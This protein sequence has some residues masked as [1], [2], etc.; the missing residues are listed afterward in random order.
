[1]LGLVLKDGSYAL[2][3]S[4][5]VGL[6]GL[7]GLNISGTF[8][9]RSNQL[10]VPVN[11]S[12]W[13]PAGNVP[14]VFSSGDKILSFGGS[15]VISVAGIFEISGTV[16][17]TKTSSGLILVDIPQISAALNING[18]R[19]FEVGGK[20]RFSIGGA[21]GFQLLDIGLTTVVVMGVNV[22]AIAGALPSLTLP[23]EVSVPAAAEL[24]TIVDGIDA[25]VLNR[26]KYID[27]TLQTPGSGTLNIESVLDSGAEFTLSGQGVADAQI[28]SVQHLEGN[29][30]RYFLTDRD[31]SNETLLFRPG[32][33]N[34]SFS[35]GSWADSTGATNVAA[36]D[37]FTARDGKATTASSVNLGPLSLTG[38]YFGLEDFQF[39]PLKNADGSLKGARI[40][41]TV[42]LGVENASFSFGGSSSALSTSITDLDGLFDVNVD[43][44]P[45]LDI[46]G[47]GMGKF[48][49]DVGSMTLNVF[50]VLIAEASGVTIQYNPEKDTDGDGVV[51]AEEQS[52]YDN[53]EIL[54][55]QNATVTITK[56]DLTGSLRPY[57]TRS[58]R[59]IPGLVVRNNGFHLGEAE[60]M[61]SGD[62]E[63]GSILNLEDIR[64]GIA[65]FGVNFS[66]GVQFNGEVYIA[67][68]GAELFPGKTFSM[69]FKDGSDAN[70]EA[71]R[72]GLTFKD[73]IPAGFKFDSDEMSMKFGDFLTVSSTKLVINTEAKGSEYVVSVGSISA[74]VKAGPLKVK[75]TLKNF[76]ITGSGT[77]VTLPGF[78]VALSMKE[79][80]PDSF[81]WPSWL[82]IT[83]TSLGIEWPDI[84]ANP[85]NF[86]LIISAK[87]NK[88]PGVPLDF[89]GAVTGLKI[90]L[91]LL[92]QGK[93]PITEV[94]S[95]A[96]T[97]G[98]D[99]GGAEISGSLLGG[100]LKLDST[101]KVIEPTDTTSVVTDRVFFVAVEGKLTILNKGFQVRFALSELGPLS[102]FVSVKAPIVLE[103]VFTGI[104]IN[105][106][107]G[108]IE[109]FTGLPTIT[110]PEELLGK[111]F[112]DAT[113][114]DADTWLST[115]KQQVA[116]QVKQVKA[117]PNIPG[118][119]AAFISPMTITAQA[120]I[121]STHLG[122]EDS[123][124]GQVQMR[125]STDGKLFAAGKFRFMN[126]RLVVEGKMYA[127]LS[128]ITKGNAKVLFLGRAPV[129]E[130]APDLR[131]LE[132]KGK[133]E[134][135]FIGPNGQPMTFSPVAAAEPSANLASPGSGA[136]IGIQKLT[137]QGYI[138]VNFVDGKKTLSES[139]ITD[140]SSELRLLLPNGTT[141]EITSTPT[142][143]TTA[144]D[145]NVYRYNLPSGISLVPG[146]YTVQFIADGVTDSDGKG[147]KYEE[148]T[149]EVAVP[150]SELAGPKHNAQIDVLGLNNSGYLTVR[151][152]GL[153]GLTL[154]ESSIT[155]A[156]AEF[157]LSGAAAA[158]V[159]INQAPEKVDATTWKYKFTGQFT[160]GP[161]S[162]SFPAGAFTDS[163][164]NS[165]VA[166]M[167][168]FTV[169]GPKITL[170]SKSMD[171]SALNAQ[172]YMEFYVE[173]SSGGTI[174]DATLTDAAHEFS[175]SGMSTANVVF[176]GAAVRQGDTQVYRYN[177]T[178]AFT[179]GEAVFSFT[180]G[181]FT[182]STNLGNVG[183]TET[184]L[185]RGAAATRVSPA[186]TVVGVSALNSQ[187]YLDVRFTPTTGY[188][189][190]TASI[191]DSGDEIL[192]TGNAADDV[193]LS[194][195][196]TQVDDVT[197]RYSFTGEFKPGSMTLMFLEG[198]MQD[199]NGAGLTPDSE[200]LEL[201][202]LTS[203]LINPGHQS[204]AG[205]NKL[206]ANGYID[207]QLD[208]VLG[209]GL[210]ESSLTDTDAEIELFTYDKDGKEQK[211]TGIGVNGVAEH[212]E[213]STWRYRFSGR[214]EPGQV[215]VRFHK[216]SWSDNAG[217]L[218]LEKIET[219]N[220]Y[221][222]AASFEIIV[223]GSAELYGA[224]ED[225]KL[226]SIKG[227]AKLS[228]DIS[229]D[230]PSARIQLDLNGR[231]DVMYFGTVGA[232]SGRFIFEI[233]PG[234]NSGFWGVMKMDT[235]F[236]KLRP[237]GIDMDATGYLQFNFSNETKI[238]TLTLPGQGPGG[239]DLTETYTLA[240]WLFAFQA[241][242][243]LIFHVPDFNEDTVF[244]T[245]LFRMSG[246]FSLEISQ[247]G[248][249]VLA[250]GTLTI[251]PSELNL[252]TLDII[253][254]L[255]IKEN[256]FAAD[257]IVTA[258]A[259]V[260]DLAS[261][262]GN[263]RL[264]TNTSGVDQEIKVPQRFIDGGYLPQSFLGRLQ[265]TADPTDDAEQQAY[266]VNAGPPLWEGGFGTPGFYA[267]MQGRASMYLRDAFV[268]EAAFRFEVSVNGLFMQAEGGLILKDIGQ[269][270][271][272]GYLEFTSAGLVVAMSLDL[273]APAL[274]TI[275]IDLDVN[276]ELLLNTTDSSKTIKPLTDGLLLED[277][278]VPANTADIKAEG[279]LAVRIPGTD[280]ELA[281]ISGVFSLD[282]ST[283]RVS[284][285]SH[286]DLEIG[287][288]GLRVFDMEV[289][290]VF[291]VVEEGFAADLTITATG[292][293]PSVAELTG[294]LRL[295][296]N[297]T[298]LAQEVPVPQRF[299]DGGFLPADFVNRLSDSALFPGRKSY[300][301]PA[302]AP[303]LDGTP[304]DPA[305]TYIVLMGQATLTLVDAWDITGG[306]RI[307][308]ETD[309]PVI[310]I[311]AKLDLG[312]LGQAN[313]D[314]KVELRVS[315]LTAVVN[316]DMDFPGL[317]AA[318]V[319]FTA[320][321]LLKV[322]TGSQDA[323]VDVDD[324]PATPSILLEAKSSSLMV[325]GSLVVRVPQTQVELISITGTFMLLI[326]SDGLSVL[327]SGQTSL[328]SLVT[329]QVDGAFF[330]RSS[331]VAAEIDMALIPGAAAAA[332]S[333][334]FNFS[335]T[336]T[337]A[338]NTT[339]APQAIEV[340]Q[341][342][343]GYLSDRAKSRL[344]T[345]GPRKYYVVPAGPKNVD[346][347]YEPAGPYAVFLM[348]GNV[349]IS[350]V[351]EIQ[352][353]F[354][355]VAANSRFEV[356]FDAY[357]TLDP[358]GRVDASGI[359]N[360]SS[361]GVYG[362]LQLGGKF[363]LGSLEIFG[364]MQLE[365]NTLST[366]VSIE[367]VQYDFE[368]RRVSDGKV[369][370]VLPA[371]AQ[372]VFVGGILSFPGFE[373]KGSFELLN[374]SDVISVS[375]D[376]SFR[377]FDALTLQ[378][379]GTVSIVKGSNPGLVM[380]VD[381]TLKA[382]FFGVEGVFDMNANFRMKVNTRTGN[383][384]DAYDLG[385]LRGMSRIDVSGEIKLL[386]TL[387]LQASGFI[388]SYAGVFRLE[389]NASM[390]ILSQNVWGTGYFSSEGEFKLAFGGSLNIGASGFGVFGSCS[391]EISRL[392][393]NG[394][395]AFGDGNYV[396]K[397]YGNMQG[398]VQMF[399]F[400]LASASITLN[401]ED[402][403]GRVYITARIQLDLLVTKV[404][405]SSSFTL[406]YI[407]I[408]KP[409]YLA[410]N[411]GDTAGTGFNRGILYLNM[412]ARAH[413]RNEAEDDANEGYLLER[414]APDPE[415]PGE[416]IRVQAFGRSQTFRG[417]TGIV[418][419]GG[420][421][422]DYI[423]IGPGIMSP[424]TLKG[425]DRKDW[426]RH[427]G[428]GTGII[429]G[430]A[431]DD[432]ILGGYGLNTF[433]FGNGFGR[434]SVHS[435]SEQN[436]FDFSSATENLSGQLTQSRLEVV[437][438]G[439]NR[440]A[441]SVE[442]GGRAGLL[443]SMGD[444]RRAVV[445][446]NHG[447]AVG[448]KVQVSCPGNVDFDGE[449]TVTS[450]TANSFEF[451]TFNLRQPA[452]TG[453]STNAGPVWHDGNQ[454]AYIRTVIDNWA[455]GH[456]LALE[457]STNAYNGVFEVQKISDSL[458]SFRTNWSDVR[459]VLD[460]TVRPGTVTL[461]TGSDTFSIPGSLAG[462]LNLFAPA[463]GTD[464]L[465]IVGS[466]LQ[467]Q[468]IVPG[469]YVNSGLTVLYSGIDRLELVDTSVDLTLSG[470]TSSD[471]VLLGSIGLGVAARSLNLPVSV[472]ADSIEINVRDSFTQLQTLQSNDLNIR[473]FGDDQNIS[474]S[475]PV[476]ASRSVQLIAPD[477]TIEL[478]GGG[479]ITS[480]SIVLKSLGLAVA[481]DLLSLSTDRL[482]VITS[483]TTAQNLTIHNDRSLL[484]TSA[485]DSTHMVQLDLTLTDVFAGISW[486]ATV[487][488]DWAAQ[489]FDGAFNPWAVAVAGIL[490]VQLPVSTASNEY[491]L[492][493]IGGL[494]SW[495][496]DIRLTADEMDFLGGPGTI[497]ATGGLTLQAASDA[498][499]Y[500]LGTSAESGG[501]A[502]VDPQYAPGMLDLPTRDIAALADGFS[503]ITI[504]R[505]SA[506]NV[507]RLGDAYSMTSVKATGEARAVDASIK[508]PI[509]LLTDSLI[510]E[511][512]FRAPL[513]S[514][515]I[516]AGRT[517]VRKV[518]LHTPNN[519]QPDSGLS[520]TTVALDVSGGLQV[521]GWIRGNNT[522]SIQ[523]TDT[524]GNY[525]L[526]TDQG[527]EILQ[528]GAAGALAITVDRGLRIAG[529]VQAAAANAS[530]AI[531][532]GTSFELLAGGDLS[533]SA[534]NSEL[535]LTGGTDIAFYP[536][537]TVR[538]GVAI[539]YPAGSP[540]YTVTGTGGQI[541]ILS[542]KE[543]LLGGLIVSSGG[544]SITAGRNSRNHASEFAALYSSNPAHYMAEHDSY[545]VLLT[546]TLT[547]LGNNEELVLSGQDEVVVTGN[548]QV[549]G[550]GS[551]L[552][553]HSEKF[554]FVEGRL[555]VSDRLAIRGGT[556]LDGTS[557]DA[558]DTR[559]SSVYL[560]AA[561]LISTTQAGS[562]ITVTGARDV[563]IYAAL[564]SGGTV[565]AGG[566]T[567][568]GD[569]S[570]VSVTAGQQIYL[571]APLHAAGS[572]LL[573]PGVPGTDDAAQ[574]L[575]MTTA[576]GLNAAGLGA[577][578]TGSVIRIESD[579]DLTLGG[580]ILSGGTI[581]Q[582]FGA[583]SQLLS[584]TYTWSGRDS[585][586]EIVSSG[587]VLVGTDAVDINGNPV[588][589]G[590]FLRASQSVS[591][592][593]DTDANGVG[594]EVYAG[595]GIT[596]NNASGA[597]LLDSAGDIDLFGM[598]VSGGQISLVQDSSG[599]TTGY[600]VTRHNGAA[601]LEI[602]SDGRVR[603]GQEVYAGKSLKITA[604][605][606]SPVAGDAYSGI[607]IV[608]QG[609]STLRT[610]TANSE[611]ILSSQS[612]IS[613][614]TS[615]TPSPETY[616]IY[617]PGSGSSVV[618]EIAT[619]SA[620]GSAIQI[621]GRIFADREIA[622]TFRPDAA[623]A[624]DLEV[625]GA[626]NIEVASST[627]R[628]DLAAGGNLL[629]RG[630][631]NSGGE[632]TL[633]ADSGTLTLTPVSRLNAATQI[634]LAAGVDVLIDSP[635]GITTAP[636]RFSAAAP[637]GSVI[638]TAA[639][640]RIYAANTVELTGE[641][642]DFNGVLQTTAATVATEDYEISIAAD[643]IKLT[644]SLSAVGSLRIDS[645]TAP[646]IY[647]FTAD[648]TAP[649]SRVQ[650]TA[651][652][653]VDI[654]R[655]TLNDAGKWIAQTA[656]I[657]ATHGISISAPGQQVTVH[658]GSV[659]STSGD[660]SSTAI[661]GGKI[662][663]VGS[664]YGG[665]RVNSDSTPTWTGTDA[666]L[667]FTASEIA[668]G[669][670]GV[671]PCGKQ[672]TRGGSVQ[673]TGDIVF[674]AIG[675]GLASEFSVNS[676]SY[677]RTMP[678]GSEA[679]PNHSE[680]ASISAFSD[681]GLAI[682]GIVD[683]SGTGADL[684]LDADDA[685]LLDGIVTA[686]DRLNVSSRGAATGIELT[687]LLF[688]TN[689]AGQLLNQNGDAIDVN[690]YLIDSAGRFIDA[691]GNL[692]PPGATP[693]SGGQPSRLSGGTLNAD[694][695]SLTASADIRLLGQTG[696]LTV[697]ANSLTSETGDLSVNAG[698]TLTV[699]GRQQ[700]SRLVDL[701]AG[702]LVVQPDAVVLAT[703]TVH[704]LGGTS[705]IEGYAGSPDKVVL[706]A[707]SSLM[708]TG[709]VQSGNRINAAAGVSAS[710]NLGQLVSDSILSSQL[711]GGSISVEQ[712]GV[713]DAGNEIRVVSGGSFDLSADAVVTPNLASITEPVIV[714]REQQISVVTGTRQVA[715]GSQLVDVITYVPTEVTEQ[716]GSTTLRVGTAYHT[717]DVALTQEGY[718]N[719][720]THREFFVQNVDYENETI[721]WTSYERLPLG[722]VRK[723][724]Q[725]PA[726]QDAVSAPE[727]TATFAQLTDD[728]KSVVLAEL[729]YLRLYR[730]SYTN[731]RRHQT[732][733]GNT[734]ITAWTPR[735]ANDPVFIHR[736]SFPGLSDKHI[737][738]PEGA[739]QDFF[740]VVSQ[741]YQ[742]IPVET[743]GQYR[744][745]ADLN[746]VQDRS[747][748][749][750]STDFQDYDQQSGR[751]YVTAVPTSP[752]VIDGEEQTVR[753]G[754][755]QYE[756]FDGRVI[757]GSGSVDRSLQHVF[758]P[759]WF[760]SPAT[761]GN[762]QSS[763][764]IGVDSYGER[765]I[766]PDG[767]LPD[768]AYVAN[769]TE[770]N[771]RP[772]IWV[773]SQRLRNFTV[774]RMESLVNSTGGWTYPPA[775]YGW[776]PGYSRLTRNDP[777]F[778]PA[779]QVESRG[780]SLSEYLGYE[781]SGIVAEYHRG[782]G[783]PACLFG[784]AYWDIWGAAEY[785]YNVFRKHYE[786]YRDYQVAWTGNWH[787]ITDYRDQYQ[788]EWRTLTEDVFG[789]VPT[790]ATFT[791][792][793]PIVQQEAQT[794]WVSENVV[795]QRT[796]IV[797]ERVENS[798]SGLPTAA[799]T[800]ESL[801][802][803]DRVSIDV[804]QDASFIGLTRATSA[805]G[806]VRVRA[807]RDVILDGKSLTDA[808]PGTLA[809]V[810]DLRAGLT[811][812]VFAQRNVELRSDAIVHAD[813]GDTATNDGVIRLHAGQ[814]LTVRSDAFGG[815]EI[816]LHS[817]G[818]VLM[819]S[820]MT[821]GHL[822][823]VRAGLGPAGVGSVITSLQT[824]LETLGS[825]IVLAAGS[826]GG[827]L[828]LTNA[829]ILTAGPIT[830]SAPAG[831][832]VHSG[833]MIVADTLSAT[834]RDNIE[835]A[836]NVRTVNAASTGAGN[837][838]LQTQG[839]VTLADISTAAG[840]VSV[841]GFGPIT[842]GSIVAG[843]S[844]GDVSIE[845]L[846]GDV[847]LGDIT[848]GG[849]LTVESDFGQISRTPGTSIAADEVLWVGELDASFELDSGDVTLIT[850]TPGDVVINYSGSSPL[851]LRQVY[852]LEGSLIVNTPGDLIVMDARLLS[853]NENYLITLNAGGNVSLGYLEAGEY[854]ATD[855][856]ADAIRQARGLEADAPLTS[857]STVTI[858]AGGWIGE[859]GAGDS[860][861][862]LVAGRAVL[863]A[864]T[865]IN[866]VTIAVNEL[867]SAIST[868]GAITIVDQD[869]VGE[870]TPG[871][872]A[873]TLSAPGGVSLIASG[874]LS[875]E[876]VI[877]SGGSAGITLKSGNSLTLTPAAGATQML[878][879]G[880][881]IAL[882]GSSILWQ[883]INQAGAAV[884]AVATSG[885]LLIADNTFRLTSGSLSVTAAGDLSVDGL[886][887]A[888]GD[889]SL[890]SISG[891]QSM[892]ADIQAGTGAAIQTLKF[893]AARDLNLLQ[894]SFPN[895][896][897]RLTISAGHELAQ[898]QS[899]LNW[900]ATGT[901]GELIV[902]AGGNLV[903][904]EAELLQSILKADYRISISSNSYI[905]DNGEERGGNLAVVSVPTGWS[906]ASTRFLTLYA[907]HY[908]HLHESFTAN[909]NLKMRGGQTMITRRAIL[910]NLAG[911]ILAD[912]PG[913]E[914]ILTQLSK[915]VAT[916]SGTKLELTEGTILKLEQQEGSG[917][918]FASD[919]EIVL[920]AGE[921]IVQVDTVAAKD[922]EADSNRNVVA[923][924]TTMA[925]ALT[926][927]GS[928]V[929]R[930]D[931]VL[932]LGA[933]NT[934]TGRTVVEAG[935]L[936]INGSTAPQSNVE[937]LG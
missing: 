747:S 666:D 306:F 303:Y 769:K 671:C 594:I 719:G 373:M 96:V 450:V 705:R 577:N 767:F 768:T 881:S 479:Q 250:Q 686:T 67:S 565:G 25:G 596:T 79:A 708:V 466:L 892:A 915:S 363:Q 5:T 546:G 899:L 590:S 636:A 55:L 609:S 607:G 158:G 352:G 819:Q 115:V 375:V 243:K 561:G 340:P 368:N 902:S 522:V 801:R 235:N 204:N 909:E 895:V 348:Q 334:V 758:E 710:W 359:L 22:S 644:G 270:N 637:S 826:K 641:M 634:A 188:S 474:L 690:G 160:T 296:G 413:M 76:A 244:G 465:R 624:A 50:D 182:D 468:R 68:G 118:F 366:P 26:R 815:H 357:M 578:G 823:D 601:T 537:S 897:N 674:S 456:T 305:S 433:V 753:N 48:R 542:P 850:R 878:T 32:T 226:V 257:L 2:T 730:F 779:T 297:L 701:R 80:S 918:Q 610:G 470:D 108:G 806:E 756:I 604:G 249:E 774:F 838:S 397:V 467:S 848:A 905:D 821:S 505:E 923:P 81:K 722:L 170:L 229:A 63:F 186:S 106:F 683:A 54:S 71:V 105:E 775:S 498:W 488:A 832:L 259:G 517:E 284:I 232:V 645:A 487:A 536:A 253:G 538:A 472:S 83:L 852:V 678:T 833:G 757:S 227:E 486:V 196:P 276:A 393:H 102:V 726:A 585:R 684:L 159:T 302:G 392:D 154:N 478:N 177:F 793:V 279:L 133:F 122:S 628:I 911:D 709:T 658:S 854:A 638:V 150:T 820:Q 543:L 920:T 217:N 865:G 380:N 560:G 903:L 398:S 117:N 715:A 870:W 608:V 451:I 760:E 135:R 771:S 824:D 759:I 214:F 589:K 766:T 914:N 287:P 648:L 162:V 77:F 328:L 386:S 860:G 148:E 112:A 391:F 24:T 502:P 260:H 694:S 336:A 581:V 404:D 668:V 411:A 605:I 410:G 532:A 189:L 99:F 51:S 653:Q 16:Q 46:I 453:T 884:T 504:G 169:A 308:V 242:G 738:L 618:L 611:I 140:S 748:L 104:T 695:V 27:V 427:H 617:A 274:K 868:A 700:T 818:D 213:G 121:S 378:V 790:Y 94:E 198:S 807:G 814:T 606:D 197:F 415:Y 898:S 354:R 195:T 446:S 616:S 362:A 268:V 612:G 623:V 921:I 770:V 364:A 69:S 174:Q 310:P 355:M 573:R 409:I 497:A 18:M 353:N 17:A 595:G 599:Q 772:G 804:G 123:F 205:R 34:V 350:S 38:P 842:A 1:N 126:N 822:I 526:I 784:C 62:L 23:P 185:V 883:G 319:D 829:A 935:K 75:G 90:D 802:A 262:D 254:V 713:L 798:V 165:S 529:H 434:D 138:D 516:T 210:N 207:V 109:F 200:L 367:R 492:T 933:D 566:V 384:S 755:R 338:F 888:S 30:F 419:D 657:Q 879:T 750:G 358:I 155:D 280:S 33:I 167:E 285:F 508:D 211:I 66:G 794:I 70:T 724:A 377:A 318:G 266:V 796:V 548:V 841:T 343:E 912:G 183:V 193:T 371:S 179:G 4:G 156:A 290:G 376:A 863:N 703:N 676:M 120:S 828:L 219:F 107:S 530:P 42:G 515:T 501:G 531:S 304:D 751:W 494:R 91:G 442:V 851:I 236:E 233:K 663:I 786:T 777:G 388:E 476:S 575:V 682:F 647:N 149:F 36:T 716:T 191:L 74:E 655:L 389:I 739:V 365:L 283:E 805:D 791:Q 547:V 85:A 237:A 430:G 495:G 97:V 131:F 72:A 627:G 134:M 86:S 429:E 20:A 707:V 843:G 220:V 416:I 173:G 164:G 447:L 399:G 926:G 347:T 812:D 813:D 725:A 89:T 374:N 646:E 431:D 652:G 934:Y 312:S 518:N 551:D 862:D 335:V 426:L 882:E 893:E 493:V 111:A 449:F 469:H 727:I 740:N 9:V 900:A 737:L 778:N 928:L 673:A 372:R 216:D 88:I 184:F 602:L 258:H 281:R 875:V 132:L 101:G 58:G 299:I 458:Y 533:V 877:A 238:E 437:P 282:T 3:T 930:G 152:M 329:M 572:L 435:S 417:V 225:L 263:F 187:G 454:T 87:V 557:L 569:G 482:T 401:T 732:V 587:K 251:G 53:Q 222:N 218:S 19:V 491:G 64:A 584:E 473:V 327:A 783:S 704:L 913:A 654:G 255:A 580:N 333:S 847:V 734:T 890:T 240:P 687:Q 651:G 127:D 432:E 269:V 143:V 544:V 718:Y 44:S 873:G 568:A 685:V 937:V 201:K 633:T 394:T 541:E 744:D 859:T 137:S 314:G 858:N 457:S 549:T 621:S 528:S 485:S 463:G 288:R 693:V 910:R 776:T 837:I 175:V 901:S 857:L 192:L 114:I 215:Y 929:K 316:V 142:K 73:G 880:G 613:I 680:T 866:A 677:V 702:D 579:S 799:F 339:G 731:A 810:A 711:S 889:V 403:T 864:G 507:M 615:S 203:S 856:E 400:S 840:S 490:D 927:T 202:E 619:N 600:S 65:D 176:D 559:G 545:S 643:Q 445:L 239:S 414:I 631:V 390:E 827:S 436:D 922:G 471:P 172:G 128:Q 387:T 736:F 876:R 825:E 785:A 552:T 761:D 672:V 692:L 664:V 421:G 762:L 113:E 292:G 171:V 679:L 670:L 773:G 591:I 698:G 39:K 781:Y 931:G 272:R 441:V 291:V 714:Q 464:T 512:D 41:I 800:N 754:R 728:Q 56:L 223:Q 406:F 267:V 370:V 325:G 830:L 461:G 423:E 527:S 100:I 124:N 513:D 144:T 168:S 555:T 422:F 588:R 206:N 720:S 151:F 598:V 667:S 459:E 84:Q 867:T 351:F 885:T 520:A 908:L 136:V 483:D 553:I 443:A 681:G 289:T 31:T 743:V 382:G 782:Q 650:L 733:N 554:V 696:N 659:L 246:V 763:P 817:D 809:A 10:G 556:T 524:D 788:F 412:G 506:G 444:N 462:T 139:S 146:T 78:G 119:L 178:G 331:G 275:G 307:K 521:S 402:G 780:L 916:I 787:A 632:V 271:A 95:I 649:D 582:Q 831:S 749:Q 688:W 574:N 614:L 21:D 525:S 320:D 7:T 278:V 60:I 45:S 14:V 147:S 199:T 626:A 418:A 932:E 835:A 224:V 420:S 563:D 157:V 721:P 635:V 455:P 405:V 550:G 656:L 248:L 845:G 341:R 57:K 723:P 301:V 221:S 317:S 764:L 273:D 906:T 40:T 752:V 803:G 396:T 480:A 887:A 98:G 190:D 252:F 808:Q 332:F 706:N 735:W 383:T 834:V 103:P 6:V 639:S 428:T 571:D 665:A 597:I 298:G 539:A 742:A 241:A 15:A 924:N 345:E 330:I 583:Q 558:A 379:N 564:V 855:A 29:T 477:G 675:A 180:T 630:S 13:T 836:L 438:S 861:V 540:Q 511:G 699:S 141:V 509:T 295:V 535:I 381:A 562:A 166:S 212:V 523:V 59:T 844:G 936:I 407:Q 661:T 208:D 369:I 917:D 484:L 130:D 93:F 356:A 153:P 161:V 395:E 629:V 669:G 586:I 519:S 894:G 230:D 891:S 265:P 344:V 481:D 361:A 231:A 129:V 247:E 503:S 245:E 425:G 496:N 125:L 567:W 311:H 886:I 286:G 261:M 460:T 853:T 620:V 712:S 534:A 323:L 37:S 691:N 846:I 324:N 816:F 293:L 163:D 228:L 300:V 789:T 839:S 43:I 603:S 181:S 294:T 322:N 625:T 313:V 741:G 697:V 811:V 510:V 904:G 11:Q 500:R 145:P 746:Y 642:V 440:R 439:Y 408:P 660:A 662:V 424:V 52:T 592:L 792:T 194:G 234:G 499:T 110:E 385:V 209:V 337:A 309:G 925:G 729:G 640:G 745:L 82:P 35:A 689:S 475:E 896:T 593:A 871:I 12:V 717:L 61:Y 256:A 514:I 47:G 342:F 326:N 28:S 622:A 907:K 448:D 277:I 797:S 92:Q 869:G 315:G 795:E 116:N 489:I 570:S 872:I 765:V 321:G 8:N 346:G 849:K 576:S 49:I 349:T 360:V 874:D 264:I 919:T 452:P